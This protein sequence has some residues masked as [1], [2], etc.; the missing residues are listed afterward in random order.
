MAK[1]ICITCIANPVQKQP[2]DVFCEKWCNYNF[3]KFQWK[4][5]VLEPATFLKTDFDTGAIL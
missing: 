4:R 2:P 1:T 5:H 3:F